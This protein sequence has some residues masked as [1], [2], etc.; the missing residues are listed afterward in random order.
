MK[1]K[2]MLLTGLA[3]L[4]FA[5]AACAENT[6][7]DVAPAAYGTEVNAGNDHEPAA[8]VY[9]ADDA[10]V[11]NGEYTVEY[12]PAE[13]DVLYIPEGN[14]FPFPFSQ[15]NLHGDTITQVDIGEREIFFVYFWATWC[16][17]CVSALPG[18]AELAEEFGDRVGFLSLL[19]DF[20]TGDISARNMTARAGIPFHTIS[21]RMPAMEPVMAMLR[22]GFVP[23]SALFD[24]N[25]NMI[26]ERIVGGNTNNFRAAIEAAL[27]SVTGDE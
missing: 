26:G 19:D 27:E 9:V 7:S 22:S 2:W 24:L 8:D 18:L 17:S 21:S 20:F 12:L 13:A 11:G 23:T 5:L 4:A 10:E 25:G 16:P 1:K 6:T 3:L 14:F 15:V